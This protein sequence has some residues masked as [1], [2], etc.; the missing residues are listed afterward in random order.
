MT[1]TEKYPNWCEDD[2]DKILHDCL[3]EQKNRSRTLIKNEVTDRLIKKIAKETI[4]ER[5]ER[6]IKE[7]KIKVEKQTKE[8]EI[9]KLSDDKTN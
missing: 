1:I 2:T 8:F 7:G 4:F 9:L 6:R 3:T 5:I